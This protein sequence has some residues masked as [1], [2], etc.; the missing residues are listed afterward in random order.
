MISPATGTSPLR[1]LIVDA[2]R[3][4][5]DS[6]CNLLRCETE[7]LSVATVGS[8]AEAL[9]TIAGSPV[10]VVVID[11]YLP[12]LDAGLALIGDLRKAHPAIRLLLMTWSADLDVAAHGVDGLLDK[13]ASPEEL[14]AAIADAAR[15]GST[16]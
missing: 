15:R 5:R 1:V 11:P 9:A 2:D 13:A 6:L 14:V 4:V 8:A 7:P 10:D 3:R 12:D 16:R